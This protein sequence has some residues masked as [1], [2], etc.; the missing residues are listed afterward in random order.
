MSTLRKLKIK[1]AEIG[2]SVEDEKIGNSHTCEVFSPRGK[3]FAC[4]SLHI[5]VEAAYRPWK[6]DYADLIDRVGYG[7]EDCDEGDDCEWCNPED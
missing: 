4:G 5:L 7:L 2:A 1:C 6:P 3:R